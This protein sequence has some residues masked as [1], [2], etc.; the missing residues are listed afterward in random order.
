MIGWRHSYH[1]WND[2]TIDHAI[3]QTSSNHYSPSTLSAVA[4]GLTT[5]K[6]PELET[7]RSPQPLE[8][9]QSESAPD[10]AVCKKPPTA[11][12]WLRQIPQ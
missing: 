12:A 5:P 9:T 2:R 1:Y 7:E 6:P 3:E 10:P 4:P 8:Q 11:L